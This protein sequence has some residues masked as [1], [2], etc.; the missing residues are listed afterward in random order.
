MK[1]M[2]IALALGTFCY[3]IANTFYAQST[4][5]EEFAK[6]FSEGDVFYNVDTDENYQ[7]AAFSDADAIDRAGQ[8]ARMKV[9]CGRTCQTIDVDVTLNK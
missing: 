1:K 2:I 3:F 4:S 9:L 6:S 8:T 7:S 5:A